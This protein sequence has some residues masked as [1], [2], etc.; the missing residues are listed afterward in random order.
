MVKAPVSVR[1]DQVAAPTQVGSVSVTALETVASNRSR[2][3]CGFRP[4]GR[5]LNP[6]PTPAPPP[7]PPT[8]THTPA[9][10]PVLFLTFPFDSPKA[11]ALC[12]KNETIISKGALERVPDPGPGFY[13]CLFLVEKASGGWRPMIDLSPFNKF[14]Q[15][16]P[17]KMET[18]S[19]VLLSVRR[20][21]FLATIGL[22]EAYF[23]IPVH[24][25]PRKWLR[26]RFGRNGPP[27]QSPL[28]RLST[29]PQVF[30]RV[31]ATVSA[32]G[33]R[34]LRY[35]DDWLVL[36]STEA[37]ARQHVRDLLSLCNS[38][39]VLLNREKSDLNP[40]QSVEYLG[41]TIDT[42]AA[43]V[44]PTVP[45]LDKFLATA[46]KFPSCQEP[47]AQLR[48]VLLEHMSSLEKLVPRGRL[49]MR[50]LQW[51]LKSYWSLE[52]DPPGTPVPAG[53][54]GPLL[55]D[56]EGPPTR[57]DT[58]RNADPRPPSILG[59][60]P[61]GLGSSPPRPVSV[62]GMVTPGELIT[63]QSPGDEGPVP[64]PPFVQGP[65]HR[66]PGDS[67]VRQFS[68]IRL[69]QQ[70]GGHSLRLP[71]LV[72]RATSPMD[73]IELGPTGGEVP[74]GTIQRPGRPAQP[75]QPS[76]GC[77]TVASPSGSEELTPYVGFPHSRPVRNF[78]SLPSCLCTAP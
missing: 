76:P 2:T 54:G 11:L 5:I 37:R 8:H 1:P 33:V 74:A 51:H 25:S 64:S 24:T 50:S 68:G 78:I 58:L 49:R 65:S 61:S 52:R 40:A 55:V 34:L 41:M 69:C 59:C 53:R 30:T 3:V 29:A 18:A 75:L 36:A 19:S 16:T 10:S 47:P 22:K 6:V 17:F 67:D 44:Y 28:L 4:Q 56:G 46:S 57:G 14:V 45:R 12:Q 70:A 7:P 35:L 73:G 66:P 39:G 20:G 77:G 9:S 62:G 71:L 23:Q 21:D 27:V 31:F 26:F 15:Q 72:D 13:S 48:Q 43:R 42:V 38:L 63:H 60:I 32:W